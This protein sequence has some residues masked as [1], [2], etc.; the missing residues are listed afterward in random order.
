MTTL[1][2]R[3]YKPA[4]A[5]L[6]LV[7]LVGVSFTQEKLNAQRTT[8]G[9]TRQ[10]DLAKNA[11]PVL[12]F[13]TVALGGFRGLIVNALWIRAMDLQDDGKYFE[14][15]Q[16][17]DWITKLQPHFTTVWVVQAWNM[18]YNISIKFNDPRDRW[19][20]VQRGIE[21]LR[22]QGL[23]YNPRETLIYRE[24]SWFYQ[25]KMG[26][27]LDD[28]H[29]FFKQAWAEEM[30]RVLGGG[31]TNYLDLLD[32]K[33]DDARRRLHLLT[34]KYKLD[35]R[36]MKKVDD[37]Y[38]PLEWRLPEAHA[39]YWA[40]QG[41]EQGRKEEQITLRR[42]V[43]HSLQL[44]FHRGRII[45][46]V[47]NLFDLGPNLDIVQ[48][49]NDSYEQMMEEDEIIRTS[50]GHKN[51]LKTAV[52]FLYSH[53]RL[54]EAAKWF[55]YLKQKY[56]DSVPRDQTYDEFAFERVQEE[57]GETSRDRTQA[58]IE[59]LYATSLYHLAMGDDDAAAGNALL[60]ERIWERYVSKTRG[61]EIRIALPA[62]KV[63]KQSALEKLLD[64]EQ[65]LSEEL[66][67]QLRS[68]LPSST[69]AP[70]ASPP[71]GSQ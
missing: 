51:F 68:K 29:V 35:P 20:W 39:V 65:G 37:L 67:R 57:V 45:G 25:H 8:L 3:L 40:V 38:G 23:K 71:S 31:R 59:G 34:E 46:N 10:V 14:M 13:T 61:S 2:Q 48:R 60:A 63:L 52:Y 41:R 32:P 24:L 47:T 58:V 26:A 27:N 6:A 42:V 70:A 28:A 53:N 7:L 4:L 5:L 69:N 44:S 33:T 66:Q 1:R 54:A 30:Q 36:A 11:P 22:D 16:L 56:P 9:L 49:A 17:A 50:P 15:V 12:V 21:L 62:L 64:P 43:F 18:A 55:A 19:M